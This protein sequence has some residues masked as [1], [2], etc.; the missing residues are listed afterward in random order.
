MTKL[1]TEHFDEILSL[2]EKYKVRRLEVFGSG[3]DQ[4]RFD[5][6]HSDLDFLVEFQS[7]EQ[8]QHAEFYFGLLE[9]LKKLFDREVDLVMPKAIKNQYFLDSVNQNRN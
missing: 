3:T 5:Q 7:L 9:D 6:D 8:G 2:C 1:V 4:S